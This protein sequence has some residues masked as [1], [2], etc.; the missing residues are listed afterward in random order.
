MDA[1]DLAR[2][3][4]LE[5]QS[6]GFRPEFGPEVA[7]ELQGSSSH[8][9][10]DSADVRDLRDRLWFSIDNADTLDLDQLS[11]AE[12]LPDGGVRLAVAVA[13]VDAKAWVGGRA[14]CRNA[15]A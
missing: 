7:R 9:D 15:G 11:W 8:G 3:A 4:A 12:A 13:D 14:A 2:I 5:M 10:A 1:N 6:H